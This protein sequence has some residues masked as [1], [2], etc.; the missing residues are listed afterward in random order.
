[1]FEPAHRHNL[2]DLLRPPN[3]YRLDSAVGTTYSMDFVALTAVM[4]AFVDAEPEGEAGGS[5][6]AELLRAIT[7]LSHRVRIFANR[8][9]IGIDRSCG[10]NKLFFCLFDR[11]VSEVRP[12]TGCFHPKVWAARYTPKDIRETRTQNR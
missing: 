6:Q 3:G 4:L 2:L 9:H 5:N 11:I 12:E 8:G 1:M 7:R 10:A